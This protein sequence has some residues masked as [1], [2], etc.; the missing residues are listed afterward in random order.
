VSLIRHRTLALAP[1]YALAFF[2]NIR[3]LAG[4]AVQITLGSDS[5][6]WLV[7]R[8]PFTIPLCLQTRHS[9]DG[10]PPEMVGF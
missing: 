9:P 7:D 1:H 3:D 8:V 5:V 4:R 2:L 6:V 10:S